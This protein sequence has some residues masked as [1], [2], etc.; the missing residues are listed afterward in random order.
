MNITLKLKITEF[1]GYQID[2]YFLIN[3]KIGKG[4]AKRF[5]KIDI[6]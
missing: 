3:H 6:E 5:L 1:Y 2:I 4:L